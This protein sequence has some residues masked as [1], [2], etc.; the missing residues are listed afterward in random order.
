MRRLALLAALCLLPV[1]VTLRAGAHEVPPPPASPNSHPVY[2]AV[3]AAGIGESGYEVRDFVL[4]KDAATFT[5]TGSLYPLEA[6]EGRV[7]GAVFLGK[8][9]MAY[10]PPLASERWMLRNLTRG[11]EF[12][13]QFERAVFRFTDDTAE[14]MAAAASGAAKPAPSQARNA[15]KDVNDALRMRLR[16]NLHVRILHDVLSPGPGGYFQAHIHGRKYS[17]RLVYTIDPQGVGFVSPEEVQL[18]SWADNRSGI[19]A[20]HHYS[21]T[22]RRRE[23]R[24]T[25]PGTWIDIEHQVL[26]TAIESN[27]EL[28]GD[29]TTTFVALVDG[30]A[31]V[32]FELFPTLRVSSVT[33]ADGSPLGWI[34]ES[35]D[36][37]ADFWV[38]LP[39]P[40]AR[41]DRFTLRTLYKGRDAVAAE[42]G[43]NFFPV[44]RTNWYPNNSGLKDY[45]TYD[46]R[47]SVPRRLKL[48]ATGDFVGEEI[49]GDRAVSRWKTDYPLSVAGFN[50]G[51]F[52][53]MEGPVG[54]YTVVA[55]AN[56]QPSNST[57]ELLKI[58]EAYRMPVGS[59]AT[60][61]SN[62]MALTEAQLALQIF[63][64]YFGPISLTR[65]HMTQQ[66]ACNFG[67]AWP[68][69]IYVPICYYWSP[70]VRQQIGMQQGNPSYWD[71]VASH[72]VAHL[73]WGHALGW[74]SYRD[75]WMSEG[76]S[77]LSASIFL[78]AA[79]PKEPDRFRD[80]WRRML[81][82]LTEKNRMGVRPIDVGP[83]TMGMRLSSNPTGA[84]A[85]AVLYPKGAY[86]LHM[87]RMMM[88]NRDAG[89]EAFKVMM[90][91]FVATHR[92]QPVT[93]AD[94]QAAVEKHMLPG[95]DLGGDGT[96]NWYFR[97]FV[98]GT[99]LPGYRLQHTVSKKDGETVL[100]V[101]ITQSNVGDGFV[102]PVPIY[103]EIQD[104]R[105]IRLGSA[106]L[107]G[108]STVEQEIP[109][110]QIPVKRA[111]LNYYYDVLSTEER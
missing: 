63:T 30:L 56:T 33:A 36:D 55:L 41:G 24:P 35:K 44:A 109:L 31:A 74:D 99:A 69:V 81:T 82:S 90:R 79:Y 22:Y 65:V 7:T 70:A 23:R 25:T 47:F 93:T 86:I 49:E 110:G 87:L 26:D 85:G 43:D 15:L 105:V 83:V 98:H 92:N 48:V 64:D 8:G 76:F 111:M 67:Q 11:E 46:M 39:A 95:M 51:H 61:S 42:G 77:N 106:T 103:I 54:D 16:E 38:V 57:K 10:E 13:E 80:Y 102:M 53:A 9:T 107:R 94:F 19:F 20:A 78:Q 29:A 75:Q 27:G 17:N 18:M 66:G 89:D 14:V 59:L 97:Q 32:P 71:S 3:R 50:V 101:R 12:N 62:K 84:A 28:T 73:W 100:S 5:L 68:G 4:K 45:A 52:Q 21:D 37:D 2:V 108:N 72:E 60:A 6:V 1:V 96:M 34:Q 91:D 40:L 88:W 104:G 58:A